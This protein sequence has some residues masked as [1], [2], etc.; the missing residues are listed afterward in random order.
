MLLI[1][2]LALKAGGRVEVPNVQ[3]M[4][5]QLAGYDSAL[6]PDTITDG[7]TLILRKAEVGLQN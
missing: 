1:D 3:E 6:I 5:R 4:Q 7:A 2:Y